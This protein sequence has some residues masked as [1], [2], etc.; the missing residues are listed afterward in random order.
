MTTFV[1]AYHSHN[2]AG[3]DY[4]SNDHVAFASD[5]RTLSRLGCRIAPLRDI[6]D[7]IGRPIARGQNETVVGIS[8]DDGPSFDF[9]DFVHPA[10]GLQRSFLNIMRDF[11]REFPAA[12]RKLH[13]TSFVIASPEARKAMEAADECGYPGLEGWLRDEWWRHAIE[14]GLMGIENHSW[15][16]VHSAPSTIV[17][18]F[19]SRNDFGRVQGY[20]D[21]NQEV[22]RASEYIGRVSGQACALFAYPFGH[23]NNY[24]AS[25]YLPAFVEEHGLIAAFGTGGRSISVD[26]SR[27]NLPRVVCG[28]HWTSPK[29]LEGLLNS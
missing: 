26:D 7:S 18:S 6:A 2:I 23:A 17:T 22:R 12:Q 8:F 4:S 19:Q 21:A 11:Q 16:H 9:E 28:H 29:E 25:E 10:F 1:L 20:V 15:D 13:A 5:L 27:W 24:L 3:T 14:S